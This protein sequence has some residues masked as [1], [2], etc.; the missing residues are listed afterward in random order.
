[1]EELSNT[2][3]RAWNRLFDEVTSNHVYKIEIDGVVEDKSQQEI[4]G[5]LRNES[6]ELRQKAADSE[7]R[8][9]HL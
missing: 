5:L 8:R 6:R 2:G 3:S 1:M 4:L 9:C 7:R